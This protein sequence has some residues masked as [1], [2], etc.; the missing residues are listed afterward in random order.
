MVIVWCHVWT[1]FL[2]YLELVLALTLRRGDIVVMDNLP[3]HKPVPSIYS[4]CGKNIGFLH[5]R[6][7]L[8]DFY[9]D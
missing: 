4:I 2:A 8:R 9:T 3:T 5:H 6:R 1:A 7:S